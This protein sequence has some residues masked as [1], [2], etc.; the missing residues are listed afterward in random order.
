MSETSPKLLANR[1]KAQRCIERGT[2]RLAMH[3][4]LEGRIGESERAHLERE[5]FWLNK[6]KERYGLKRQPRPLSKMPV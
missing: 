5:Q 4:S 6:E 3:A 2:E 1:L